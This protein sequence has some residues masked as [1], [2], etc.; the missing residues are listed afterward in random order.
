MLKKLSASSVVNFW[1]QEN[2]RKYNQL[3]YLI[4][5]FLGFLSLIEI[6]KLFMKITKFLLFFFF[7]INTHLY[8]SQQFFSNS[9]PQILSP[10]QMFS[11][12]AEL[13]NAAKTATKSYYNNS[14]NM[15]FDLSVEDEVCRVGNTANF[16]ISSQLSCP[17][18]TSVDL[19]VPT[20]SGSYVCTNQCQYKL[21][22]CVDVDFES[23]MT[24]SA[25][26]TGQDCGTPK[27]VESSTS[28]PVTQDPTNPTDKTED[29]SS[30]P[31]RQLR[32]HI[33]HAVLYVLC[34]LPDRQLR[35]KLIQAHKG[36]RSSLP[37]RQLR[38][39]G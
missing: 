39:I 28:P 23:G 3:D 13:C 34:S 1:S 2:D 11:S 19:K 10:T 5:S 16:I 12:K 6:R 37:D 24:C 21:R 26:S 33:K 36:K 30:L 29:Q 18:A 20:N 14:S 27:P 15:N 31:D 4:C 32:N 38:K 25:I 22:A 7:F 17:S 35:K 8:A 9:N